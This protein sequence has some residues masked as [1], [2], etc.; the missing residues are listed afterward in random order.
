[1]PS[2]KH[3][4]QR[5]F[6]AAYPPAAWT[7][8]ALSLIDDTAPGRASPADQLHLTIHFI[9]PAD[10][11]E[12]DTIS[13]SVARS[14]SGLPPFTLTPTRI[15]ALPKPAHARVIA[16][17]CAP[18]PT[19]LELHRRLVLRLARTAK[20][21]DQDRF[22]PHLTIRRLPGSGQR[23]TAPLDDEAAA[24]LGPFEVTHI[25]LMRSVL[26]DS[27]AEHRELSRV[28]L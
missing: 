17:E 15:I 4:P 6:I 25:A 18:D 10:P 27:G 24:A 19:L 3:T 1:M 13:E 14:A 21:K 12:L 23:W 2:P 20:Q 16:I 22:L 11:R 5:L 26:T 28:A 7:R 8:A 9:G